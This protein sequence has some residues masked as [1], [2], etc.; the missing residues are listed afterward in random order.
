[1]EAHYLQARL[2]WSR[3]DLPT[4]DREL[5]RARALGYPREPLAR[6]RGLA[7]A[8]TNQT[9]QAEP[10]LRQAF[11]E[12]RTVDPEVAEALAR[13]YLGPSRLAA[14]CSVLDR[15]IRDAPDDARPYLL[16]TEIDSRR[17]VVPDR[18]IAGYRAALQRD[19]SL[20]QARLGLADQLRVAHR[21]AEASA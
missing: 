5:G 13:L 15:W 17:E 18:L 12:S 9:S 11:D 4:V 14:A 3:H 7:L 10:L 19:R 8:R 6:L 21:N 16:R 1:G 2:A 20:D